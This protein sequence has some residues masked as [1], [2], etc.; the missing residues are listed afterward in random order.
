MLGITL[1]TMVEIHIRT[2]STGWQCVVIASM[3][4]PLCGR[5][6]GLLLYQRAMKCCIPILLMYWQVELANTPTCD[7]GP[8]GSGL[9]SVMHQRCTAFP[10]ILPVVSLVGGWGG[11]YQKWTSAVGQMFH[12]HYQSPT[13]R[14]T[15]TLSPRT[16]LDQQACHT[17]RHGNRPTSLCG[18]TQRTSAH[19]PLPF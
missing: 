14:P 17:K 3:P 12:S 4:H 6:K 8:G 13:P 5:N 2:N 19:P 7:S 9:P 15:H 11:G 16:D 1:L 10:G 18:T